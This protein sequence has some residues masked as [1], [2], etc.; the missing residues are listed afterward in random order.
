MTKEEREVIQME[1]DAVAFEDWLASKCPSGDYESVMR[2]WE[3]SSE[4][5]DC[6]AK[7]EQIVAYQ[8]ESKPSDILSVED[9]ENIDPIWHWMYRPLYTK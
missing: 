4:Y 1:L 3:S 2:Q 8:S 5:R 7:P 6:F 9:Y